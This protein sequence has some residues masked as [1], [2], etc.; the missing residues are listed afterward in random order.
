[1]P[2]AIAFQAAAI[3]SGSSTSRTL[4]FTVASAAGQERLVALSAIANATPATVTFTSVAID[5]QSA[6]LV[7]S[8]ARGVDAG[9]NGPVVAFFRAAGTANTSINVTCT[10]STG[11][12]FDCRGAVWTLN[13][14]GSLLAS[15]GDT[16]AGAGNIGSLDLNANTIADGAA[17]AYVLAYSNATRNITWSGLTERLDG[18]TPLYSGDWHSAADLNVGSSSTPLTIVATLP[19]SFD[20]Q[21]AAAGVALSFNPVEAGT[22]GGG[23]VGQQIIDIGDAINDGT[24]DPVRVAFDKCNHNFTE[25]YE[26]QYE[27]VSYSGTEEEPIEGKI[28]QFVAGGVGEEYVIQGVDAATLGIEGPAGPQGDPGPTGATGPS[29]PAGAA[30]AAGPQVLLVHRGRA[31]LLDHRGPP[32]PAVACWRSGCSRPRAARPTRPPAA[33]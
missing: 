15:T 17:A 22:D 24:G 5:G 8:Y 23:D 2:A 12:V 27:Y 9:G 31:V 4:S 19:T 16:A 25:L 6:T 11:A 10:I 7:G 33:W 26:A 1:M 29:G 18:S 28:A 32:A 3:T 21:S 13:D 14:A 30:G 20:T